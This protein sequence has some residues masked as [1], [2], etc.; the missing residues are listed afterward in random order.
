MKLLENRWFC[1]FVLVLCQ[2]VTCISIRGKV[3]GMS[4]P[5]VTISGCSLMFIVAFL[6][7]IGYGKNSRKD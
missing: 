7:S 6:L 4:Q 2:A 1:I 5:W 3:L